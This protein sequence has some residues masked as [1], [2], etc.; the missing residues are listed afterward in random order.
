VNTDPTPAWC[1][2]LYHAKATELIL[3]GRALGLSHAEAED[4]VQETFLALW[5]LRAEPEHPAHYCVR[6][7]RHRVLNYRRGF[8]RRLTR[9]LESQ[10][11][12]ERTPEESPAERAAM[13]CLAQ[14]PAP[15]REVIVLKLWH[16]YTFETIGELLAISPNTAA[17]RYR[18]GLEKLRVC[19][20]EE[21]YER[22]QQVGGAVTFL[23]AAPPVSEA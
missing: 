19:L 18:Y 3:Y 17:G 10:R 4:V 2:R 13:R 1:E 21:D 6:S 7:F 5:Q 20:R 15:Q 16:D 23:D 8:W 22:D 11:W 12:F 9:E 14:L